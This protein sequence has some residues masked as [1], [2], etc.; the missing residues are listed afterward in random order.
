MS[1][2]FKAENFISKYPDSDPPGYITTV[3]ATVNAQDVYN[4]W[5]KEHA[6]VF[7]MVESNDPTIAASWYR[8]YNPS[9]H[10]HQAYL[11]DP[12]PMDE[13]F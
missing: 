12:K 8:Y 2:I 5:L 4:K 3:E 7:C 13:I 9:I 6:K 11:V 10:T 1:L